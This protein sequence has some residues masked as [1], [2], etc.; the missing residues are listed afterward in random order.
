MIIP[1]SVELVWA[2]NEVTHVKISTLPG[3]CLSG[4]YACC[5]KLSYFNATHTNIHTQNAVYMRFLKCILNANDC[6][7]LL[8]FF[9]IAY[10]Q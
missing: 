6:L 7:I 2:F 10:I 8:I 3:I 5:C 9:D 4:L 1:R